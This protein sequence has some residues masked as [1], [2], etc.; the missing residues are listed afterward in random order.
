ML[1]FGST[2]ITLNVADYAKTGGVFVF[3]EVASN[4]AYKG[5]VPD[6][7]RYALF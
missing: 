1:F 4:G 3:G 7:H 2:T 6:E 5:D